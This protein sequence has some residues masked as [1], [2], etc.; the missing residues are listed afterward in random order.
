MMEVGELK[1]MVKAEE[2]DGKRAEAAEEAGGKR[3]VAEA[4]LA[5][6]AV[7]EAKRAKVAE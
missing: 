7:A 3:T 1:R 2:A 6:E 4:T 5:E